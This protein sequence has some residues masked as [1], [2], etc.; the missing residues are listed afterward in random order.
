MGISWVIFGEDAFEAFTGDVG[1]DLC[2]GDVCVT[3]HFQ[4]GEEVC[5]CV[6]EVCGEVVSDLVG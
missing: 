5:A 1:V 6:E 4:Y 3:K 2:G